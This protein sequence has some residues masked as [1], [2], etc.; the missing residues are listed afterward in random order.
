MNLFVQKSRFLKPLS[1]L[2]ANHCHDLF[3]ILVKDFFFEKIGGTVWVIISCRGKHNNRHER[4]REYI[5]CL[6]F[7]LWNS[8]ALLQKFQGKIVVNVF[9][10][11]ASNVF[12]QSP[13]K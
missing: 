2:L 11:G 7:F 8:V 6:F 3:D 12:E 5:F 1:Y 9:S 13:N 10:Y 4:V